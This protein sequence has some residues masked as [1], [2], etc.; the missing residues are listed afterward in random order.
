MIAVI[1]CGTTN[2][3]IYMVDRDGV[4]K[5]S[6]EKKVGVRDTAITGSR[7]TLRNGI[8]ELFRD[9]IAASG[10]KL[11]DI[12][13]AVASGMI[14]SEIGLIELPHL[15]GPASLDQF[16]DSAEVVDD[17]SI[18]SLGVPMLFI[19]GVKNKFPGGAENLR[20][21][22]FLRGEE[23]QCLGLIETLHPELPVNLTVLSSH[24]KICHIDANGCVSRCMTT[25]SGQIYEALMT[26]TS[27]GKSAIPV[28]GEDAGGYSFE[29]LVDIAQDCVENAGLTRTLL[30]P[31]FMQV[32]LKTNADERKTFIDASIAASDIKAFREFEAQGYG[33]K[34]Y[35]LFG[36]QERCRILEYMLFKEYG[37][38]VKVQ[39]I[40]DKQQIAEITV[41]G[42]FKVATEY[43]KKKG[44]NK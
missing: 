26:A 39:S 27:V 43:L 22:D 7:D 25:L 12:D 2:T 1:D 17:P 36:H 32:L 11:E 21:V 23:V 33:T 37:G 35:I 4:I 16:I 44:M 41:A 9:T 15:T 30:M 14:T 6:G 31:R 18:L 38:K 34:L 10:L 42:S 20:Q 8:Q 24:T 40:Y 13:L 3:R 5:N 28:E 19:R 29:Q